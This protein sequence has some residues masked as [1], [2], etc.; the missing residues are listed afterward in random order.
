MKALVLGDHPY[1]N[2][3]MSW[4]YTVVP[5]DSTGIDLVVF[6]GGGDINPA[7]YDEEPIAE[8]STPDLV[9]DSIE[10]KVFERAKE[11]KIP[12]YGICRGAQLLCA[13]NGGSIIQHVESHTLP[14][15][16][17][18]NN[19]RVIT[20]TSS[21]HQMMDPSM[22]EGHQVMAVSHK[23]KSRFY[24]TSVGM[25]E[26]QQEVEAVYFP[27]TKSLCTQWHPEWSRPGS[28]DREVV[29]TWVGRL[30]E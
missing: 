22:V 13:M 8:T 6:T 4:G 11:D 7:L 29:K 21:H 12:M 23:N 16:A 14:H 30:V 5:A 26:C 3:L 19:G 9:R 10:V 20:V 25:V 27:K 2:L 24:K 17:K 28:P 18:L 1:K 15:S